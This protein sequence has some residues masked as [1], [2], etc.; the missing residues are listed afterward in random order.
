MKELN[1]FSEKNK[2]LSI[3]KNKSGIYQVINLL[4]DKTYV[5]SSK[6]IRSRLYV[7]YNK[8]RLISSNMIIYKG[9]LKYGYANFDFKIIEYCNVKN[10]IIREQYYIDTLKPEYNLLKLAGSSLGYKHT[11][12]TIS[13]FKTRQVSYNTRLNLSNAAKDRKLDFLTKTKISLLHK[14]KKLTNLTKQKI[15]LSAKKKGVEVLNTLTKQIVNFNSITAAANTIDVS[16]AS[17]YKAIKNKRKC[18]KI[19]IIKYI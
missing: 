12:E 9:L 19:Y 2:L 15:S 11:E 7:Y 17:I 8:N 16:R 1:M 14:G 18:K 6:D 13:K 10:L 3:T 5:G 4:N